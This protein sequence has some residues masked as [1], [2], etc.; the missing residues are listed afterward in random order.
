MGPTRFG[1]ILPRSSDNDAQLEWQGSNGRRGRE[2]CEERE[3]R[4]KEGTC[5]TVMGED[6]IFVTGRWAWGNM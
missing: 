2:G 1:R 5:A 4:G 3:G 6:E